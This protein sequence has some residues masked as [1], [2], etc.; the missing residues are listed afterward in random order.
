V[1][2]EAARGNHGQF[3]PNFINEVVEERKAQLR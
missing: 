2:A 1:G 3:L